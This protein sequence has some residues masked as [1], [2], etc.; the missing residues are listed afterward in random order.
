MGEGRGR[1]IFLGGG[2]VAVSRRQVMAGPDGEG[3]DSGE[4]AFPDSFDDISIAIVVEGGIGR[5]GN[6]VNDCV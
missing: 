1:R 2:E 5:A 6:A 4:T 3:R